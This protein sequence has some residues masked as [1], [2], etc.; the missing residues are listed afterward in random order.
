MTYGIFLIVNGDESTAVYIGM[1]PCETIEEAQAEE[2]RL[3]K[4]CKE[5]LQYRNAEFKLWQQ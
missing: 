5:V 4:D 1:Y 3:N 2:S